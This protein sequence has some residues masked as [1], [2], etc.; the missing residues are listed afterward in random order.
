MGKVETDTQPKNG[1]RYERPI[2]I[3]S[4]CD[5]LSL[6]QSMLVQLSEVVNMDDIERS[7][8]NQ[9]CF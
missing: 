7:H 4:L 8:F 9:S 3:Q 2:F 1:V 5:L 6:L